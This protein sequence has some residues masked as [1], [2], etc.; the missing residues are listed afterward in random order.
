MP[1]DYNAVDWIYRFTNVQLII[2]DTGTAGAQ[3]YTAP[4]AS[5]TIDLKDSAVPM[6]S[7]LVDPSKSLPA[8]GAPPDEESL[9]PKTPSLSSLADFYKALQKEVNKKEVFATLIATVECNADTQQLALTLWRIIGVGISGINAGGSFSPVITLAHPVYDANLSSCW[10]PNSKNISKL[11]DSL[12]GTNP[13]PP[14][15]FLEACFA[16]VKQAEKSLDDADTSEFDPDAPGDKPSLA[17]LSELMAPRAREACVALANN[18]YWDNAGGTDIPFLNESAGNSVAEIIGRA[19]WG[20]T[21]KPSVSVW[22]MFVGAVCPAFEITVHGDASVTPLIVSPYAPWG[23]PL[24]TI[25]D[26]DIAD[27]TL[28]SIDQDPLAGVIAEYYGAASEGDFGNT[29]SA[30]TAATG[31]APTVQEISVAGGYLAALEAGAIGKI[32]VFNPPDWAR[33]FL[34]LRATLNGEGGA[35]VSTSNILGPEP[36]GNTISSAYSGNPPPANPKKEDYTTYRCLL[37]VWT[38]QSF[39]R[40]YRYSMGVSL[41]TRLMLSN[42]QFTALPG[43]RMRPGISMTVKARETDEVIFHFYATSV[44]HVIDSQNGQAYTNIQGSY[45]RSDQ[46]ILE[47][48][49]TESDLSDGI[50]NTLY[51]SAGELTTSDAPSGSEGVALS[52]TVATQVSNLEEP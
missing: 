44:Q 21:G 48:V 40:G 29:V 14:Q 16:Y 35:S 43:N 12:V 8:L 24:I 9:R 7:V 27:L 5:I 10:I 52:N 13:N 51:D 41:R 45:L 18:L 17:K 2:F 28:P 20:Y 34:K 38:K 49:I 15:G 23:K 46:Q 25:Y 31:G 39:F 6:V 42:P 47:G 22:N 33:D 32:N 37:N 26:D 19:F 30:V 4:V 50:K 36:F 11:P 3:P 1:A